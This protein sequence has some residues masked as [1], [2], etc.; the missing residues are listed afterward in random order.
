MLK[1]RINVKYLHLFGNYVIMWKIKNKISRLIFAKTTK[2][3][4]YY[5]F[6]KTKETPI[7]IPFLR[8]FR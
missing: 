5:V 2:S 8:K 6:D 4:C 3:I 1:F 7:K